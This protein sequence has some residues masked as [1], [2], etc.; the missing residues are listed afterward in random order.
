VSALV[1][2]P[3]SSA[4]PLST[5]L[6]AEARKHEFPLLAADYALH[7]VDLARTVIEREIASERKN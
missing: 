2:A 1:I 7:F 4:H 3:S 5:A 6:I